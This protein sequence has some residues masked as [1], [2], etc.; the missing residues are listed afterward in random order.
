MTLQS[1]AKAPLTVV[2]PRAVLRTEQMKPC[3]SSACGLL[4][5]LK[6]KKRKSSTNLKIHMIEFNACIFG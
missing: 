1:N 2:L 3:G 5:V 6:K 4:P